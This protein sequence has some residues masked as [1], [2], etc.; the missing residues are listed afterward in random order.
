VL[1]LDEPF[2]GLNED[3]IERTLELIRGVVGFG[4]TVVCIEH[5]M[6][7]LVQL[8]SRVMV[9][10]HGAVFFEGTAQ[11]MMRDPRV[12]EIYLGKKAAQRGDG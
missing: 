7:A 5:V 12:I 10:H 2:G 6:R 3:E 11:E 9:M 8:A 4:V 1:L